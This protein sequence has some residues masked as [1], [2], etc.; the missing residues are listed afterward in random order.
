MIPQELRELDAWIAEHVT[1]EKYPIGE[2]NSGISKHYLDD[3]KNVVRTVEGKWTAALPSYTTDPAAAMMVLE[4]CAEKEG[5]E[6]FDGVQIDKTEHGW[7]VST[8]K[9][10]SDAETLPLAICLFAKKLFDNDRK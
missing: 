6:N 3:G 5:Q 8:C 10:D 1:C 7:I 9:M 2:H 4:K